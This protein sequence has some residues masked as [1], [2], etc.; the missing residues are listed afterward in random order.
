MMKRLFS[1]VY[2]LAITLYS[3]GQ[4][5]KELWF[6]DGYN[7]LEITSNGI[8]RIDPKTG[9]SVAVLTSQQLTPEGNTSPIKVQSISYSNDRS[10]ILLFANTV[11]VWR[12]NTKGEYFVFDMVTGKLHKVG[13]MQKPQTLMFAKFSPDGKKV[14][15]VSENN[16][17]VEDAAGGYATKLTNDGQRKLINGTFDWVYEEEFGCRDGFRW[18]PDSRNL[19]FW[20]VDAR[21]IRDFYM[22]NNTDSVYSKVMPV[23]YP[24]AGQN[25]SPVKIGVINVLNGALKWMNFEG[26]AVQHYIP[27]MEWASTK[28]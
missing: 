9:Q 3:F 6:H 25:P 21:A 24:V 26:D 18:S 7:K 2:L 1:I 5:Q 22:I 27:R 4:E 11:K 14:A 20:Q 15:F 12:Y 28:E 10:K 19:A 16:L 23:E 8:V 17:F 13:K